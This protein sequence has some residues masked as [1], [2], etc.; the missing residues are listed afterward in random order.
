MVSNLLF[1]GRFGVWLRLVGGFVV[2]FGCVV[3]VDLLQ[4][5]GILVA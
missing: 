1:H 4:L 2:W 5:A 3:L